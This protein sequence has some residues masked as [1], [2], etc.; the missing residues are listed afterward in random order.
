[1]RDHF[2]WDEL[3]VLK[4]KLLVKSKNPLKTIEDYRYKSSTFH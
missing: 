4:Q 1:M 2:R 3:N